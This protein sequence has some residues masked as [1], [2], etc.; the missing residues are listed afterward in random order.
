MTQITQHDFNRRYGD[1]IV[2][3]SSETA[4]GVTFRKITPSMEYSVHVLKSH[5]ETPDLEQSK[6]SDIPAY[7]GDAFNRHTF[8]TV[9]FQDY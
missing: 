3:R 1:I 8:E 7:A 5:M 9:H 6:I 2:L 4:V